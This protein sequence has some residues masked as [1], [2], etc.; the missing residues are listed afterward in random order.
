MAGHLFSGSALSPSLRTVK[1]GVSLSALGV[2]ALL[3][4]HKVS[5]GGSVDQLVWSA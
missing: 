3:T 5:F 4:L 1:D 2:V